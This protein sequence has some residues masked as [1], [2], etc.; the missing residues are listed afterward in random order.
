MWKEVVEF[1]GH[2]LGVAL[3]LFI[4]ISALRVGESLKRRLRKRKEKNASR[5]I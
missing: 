4:F 2:I 1:L 5:I 3:G